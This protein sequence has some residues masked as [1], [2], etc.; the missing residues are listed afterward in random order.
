MRDILISS[1]ICATCIF[2]AFVSQLVAPTEV[3]AISSTNNVSEPRQLKSDLESQNFELDPGISNPKLF[4]M[5]SNETIIEESVETNLL[6]TENLEIT[7]SGLKII[8][9]ELGEGETAVSG[10]TVFVNY[11]GSLE[12]G[13]EFDSSYSRGPFNFQ[14]G[15]GR[16]I[17]GWEEGITGMKIG[18]KRTLI[19][20]P[21]LA[22]GSRGAGGVIPPDATLIFD[23]ELLDIKK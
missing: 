6:Q 9:V 5:A 20:P 12:N 3:K 21:Q 15:A 17:K 22:Y 1:A 2:F 8:D 14:L 13:T 7:T 23:V 10:Q 16:V 18:G 11:R 4:T 19:I